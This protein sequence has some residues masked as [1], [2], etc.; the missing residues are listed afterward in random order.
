MP[1]PK[2]T[3]ALP[4]RRRDTAR[5]AGQHFGP[6][7]IEPGFF[8]SAVE[9]IRS[10]LLKPRADVEDDAVQAMS[11]SSGRP[12]ASVAGGIA[13]IALD[14]YMTKGGSSFGGCSTVAV[15]QAVRA[16]TVDPTVAGIMLVVSSPGGTIAGTADLADDVAAAAAAKPTHCYIED[17]GCSAAYWVASQCSRVT[18]NKTAVVGSIGTMILLTDD[19]AEQ[20]QVGIRY[21]VV[22]TGPFKG[23]GADGAITD[24]T[25][26]EA[27]RITAGQN[28]PFL[29]AV[30]A[31][32]G[33]AIP[34]VGAVA[35][36]RVHVGAQAQQLGLVDQIA[37]IDAAMAALLT[38]SQM[39]TLEQ[40]NAFATAHPDATKP[41]HDT[42][43][44]LGVVAGATAERDRF[45][46]LATVF[47]GRHEFVAEQFAAG[48][49]VAGANVAFVA[50]LSAENQ[51]LHQQ[52]AAGST[53]AARTTAGTAAV[54]GAPVLPA[55]LAAAA[56]AG[57]PPI[58]TA[59]KGADAV[60]STNSET[61][62]A[63]EG[64]SAGDDFVQKQR[65]LRGLR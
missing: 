2:E 22:S 23:L 7:A 54:A 1:D 55:A 30:A 24:A 37:S 61:T 18:A 42:G 28:Q 26:A 14:G 38:E 8:R 64:K 12:V 15:R 9:N 50:V 58:A 45:K 10:G 40:F 57:R 41:F 31:G 34:D 4:V 60:A 13:T 44:A 62:L 53:A 59:L 48:H 56:A 46:A 6:W 43:H 63:A 36:G 17:V 5:C 3:L 16:A 51:A 32:R 33:D 20:E 25:V 29:A 65:Q 21:T 47:P 35:D 39:D 49:D 19:T 11:E 27:Q 52:L